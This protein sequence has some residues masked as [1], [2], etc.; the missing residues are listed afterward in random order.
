MSERLSQEVLVVCGPQQADAAGYEQLQ[1]T[2]AKFPN[3]TKAVAMP[4][5]HAGPGIPIGACFVARGEIYPG[6][7]GTDIGCG[8][9]LFATH[10]KD[11]KRASQK[12]ASR[13][14]SARDTLA[15]AFEGTQDLLTANGLPLTDFD[16]Q[17]GTLGGGNHFAEFLRVDKILNKPLFVALH[18]CE[19]HLMLLVHSGSRALGRDIASR[20]AEV[21]TTPE[22]QAAYLREHDMAVEWALANRMLIAHRVMD[23]VGSSEAVKVLNIVHN[24]LQANKEGG[25]VDTVQHF[26]H[27]KGVGCVAPGQVTIIPGSRGTCSFLVKMCD[28]VPLANQYL[29]SVAHGA[30]RKWCRSKAAAHFAQVPAHKLRTTAIGSSVVCSDTDL[31]REEHSDAYKDVTGVVDDLV[32]AGLVTVVARLEP[33]CTFKN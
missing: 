24:Y 7:I 19:A 23:V 15:L 16:A 1:A 22:Q 6:L 31:L 8:M 13:L 14:T 12:L 11:A 28:D 26:L 33:V 32:S 30:G 9:T 2:L 29:C 17:L 20:H 25:N 4:D 18:L 10:I 27:R 5:L 21:L 3:I